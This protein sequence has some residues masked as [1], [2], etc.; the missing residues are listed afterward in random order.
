MKLLF[1]EWE[2]PGPIMLQGQCLLIYH[3]SVVEVITGMVAVMIIL[4]MDG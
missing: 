3:S 1:F 4:I 2:G